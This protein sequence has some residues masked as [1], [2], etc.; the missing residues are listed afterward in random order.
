M[1]PSRIPHRISENIFILGSYEFLAMLKG[2]IRDTPF[3]QVISGL[4]TLCKELK[5]PADQDSA[6]KCYPIGWIGR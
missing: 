4:Q 3:Y 5:T 1:W 6:K 2:K